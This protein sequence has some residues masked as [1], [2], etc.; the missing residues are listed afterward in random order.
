VNPVSHTTLLY[1]SV[2][3]IKLLFFYRVLQSEYDQL[4]QAHTDHVQRSSFNGD[5]ID[6]VIRDD[7]QN[8]GGDTEMIAE[9]QLLR[10]HKDR[11]EARMRILEDHN[12]QLDSQLKHL[13]QLLNNSEQVK[14]Y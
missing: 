7:N 2:I 1:Q 14:V 11:L 5:G 10:Q 9:A 12:E 4:K 3:N 6:D 13:R 8:D